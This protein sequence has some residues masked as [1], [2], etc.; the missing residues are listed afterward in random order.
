MTLCRNVLIALFIHSVIF[1]GIAWAHSG[2]TGVVKERM[3]L[4]KDI[5]RDTKALGLAFKGTTPYDPVE[6]A[7][8]A[9]R[10]S[11]HAGDRLTALFPA[12]SKFGNLDQ[13]D[14]FQR[15]C[16]RPACISPAPCRHRVIRANR[17]RPPLQRSSCDLQGLPSGLPHRLTI[18]D[19]TVNRGEAG[20]AEIL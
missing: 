6:I 2:A 10:I 14:T 15:D 8:A 12:G 3:Q 7:A 11:E 19:G 1:A 13:L 20:P 9:E 4:M 16:R 17:N 5:A 18:Q